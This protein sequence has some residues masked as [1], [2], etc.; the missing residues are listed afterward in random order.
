MFGR[1]HV[2]I[3]NTVSGV[4]EAE[5]AP[6]SD[7]LAEALACGVRWARK[8]KVREPCEITCNG[9]MVIFNGYGYVKKR[10]KRPGKSV[11]E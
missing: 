5:V 11:L 9:R 10:N 7:S 8:L 2:T 1:Y 3:Y 4:I 6:Y